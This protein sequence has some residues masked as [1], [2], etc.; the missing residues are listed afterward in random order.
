MKLIFHPAQLP[1]D[2]LLLQY[3]NTAAQRLFDKLK[4]LDIDSL[5]I[6][7]YTKKYL[8]THVSHLER[9]LQ[10]YSYIMA[11]SLTSTRPRCVFTDYGGGAGILSFLAKECGVPTVVYTDIYDVSCR[12]VRIIGETIHNKPDYY[13]EGD[14]NDVIS[15]FKT[16]GLE[17]DVIASYDVIE[18]I[19]DIEGFFSKL[20]DIPGDLLTVVM[21]SGANM[22]H[23]LI[24]RHIMKKQREI[25]HKNRLEEWGHKKRDSLQAYHTIRKEIIHAYDGNLTMREVEN[26]A[27]VTRGK[28]K[29]DILLC[30]DAYLKTGYIPQELN[31]PTNTCDPYTGNWAEHLMNPYQLRDILLHSGFDAKLLMGYYGH[32]RRTIKHILGRILNVAIYLMGK[33]GIRIAPFFTIYGKRKIQKE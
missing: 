24:R 2:Q 16:Q 12:D 21:A 20:H 23:P 5:T 3:I 13:V 29:A 15:F 9:M 8:S 22:Y 14:I 11:W 28:I 26:L 19:Y 4:N 17:C 10:T 25:E 6:S 30:V 32:Y 1:Q 18:H 7:D 33:H 31:H 27:R